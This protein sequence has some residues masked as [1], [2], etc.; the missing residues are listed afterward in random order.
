MKPEKKQWTWAEVQQHGG[1]EPEQPDAAVDPR[2]RVGRCENCGHGE[3]SLAVKLHHL[4]RTCQQ[5]G[6][7]VDTDDNMQVIGEGETCKNG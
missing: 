6:R 3:F 4:L 2:Q 5:C 7:E 1:K